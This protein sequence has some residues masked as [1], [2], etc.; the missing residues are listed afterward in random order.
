MG[1]LMLILSA[2]ALVFWIWAYREVV[3]MEREDD[4]GR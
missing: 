1:T 2:A 3:K 4:D